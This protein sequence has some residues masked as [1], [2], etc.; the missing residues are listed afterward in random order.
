M[1]II[2]IIIWSSVIIFV[3]FLI[4]LSIILFLANFPRR[5]VNDFPD[6]GVV[7]EFKVPTFNGKSMECWVVYPTVRTNEDRD[8][9]PAII[10]IHGWGR[11]RGRMVSRA[12]IYGNHGYT[13]ILISV[14]DHG[15]SDK[16]ITGMSIVRFSQDLDSCVNW[17]GK[18]VIITGHSIGAGATLIVA[19]R[20]PLVEAVIAEASPYAFP[21]SLKYVYGPVLKWF[22]PFLM[23]GITILT[24]IK[25]RKFS[26]LEF[27]PLEAAPRITVPTLLIHGRDDE[28]LPSK[29]TTLLQKEILNSKI[30]IPDQMNHHN[31]EEHPDYSNQVIGFIK[32]NLPSIIR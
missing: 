2:Q 15:N 30:W 19:A 25:F 27:S 32:S 4:D 6:W 13:T 1:I 26:K 10:L 9:K 16:E 7:K 29:Y 21:H 22:T 8:Q 18:P 11:N 23:P 12:R 24:L 3:Y 5:S 31:I 28:I 14:R 20:N 17:W